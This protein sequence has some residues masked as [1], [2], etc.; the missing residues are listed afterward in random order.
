MMRRLIIA[1]NVVAPVVAV[2]L[3]L[4]GNGLAGLGVLFLAHM[5]LLAGTLLPSCTWL[6]PV[7]TEFPTD[8]RVVWL[9]IDDGPDPRDTP[10]I[11]DL[12]DAHDAKATFFVIGEKAAAHPELITEIRRR[13]HGIGNHTQ[14]HPAHAFWRLGPQRTRREIEHCQETLGGAPTLFRAPAGM[15]N[16]FVHPVL[17]RLGL[18]LVGWTARGFD[19]RETDADKVLARIRKGLR[20]GAIVL[21]HE[22]RPVAAEVI[23]KLL[24]CLKAEGYRCVLPD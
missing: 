21:V 8:E 15:R 2:A 9:T 5:L 22:A 7:A 11:L 24:G 6:G 18:R 12:L 20:P 10:M 23:P 13:G 3:F 17:N 4:S 19:G 16:M 14:S 1:V